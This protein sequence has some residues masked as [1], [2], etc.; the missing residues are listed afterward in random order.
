MITANKKMQIEIVVKNNYTI[1]SK[2]GEVI[3]KIKDTEPYKSGYSGFRTVNNHMLIQN[4]KV[5]QLK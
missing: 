4:F 1:Y 5:T 2:D 3:Y